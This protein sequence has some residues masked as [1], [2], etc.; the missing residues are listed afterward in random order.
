MKKFLIIF[1]LILIIAGGAYYAFVYYFSYSHGYRA[2]ELVKF[3]QKGV[4]F[5]TW[6]GQI[7]QE[8]T[9]PLWDFSVLDKE[10]EVIDL[11]KNLQGKHVKLTYKERFKTFPWWGDTHYFISEVEEANPQEQSR[12]VAVSTDKNAEIIEELKQENQALRE[13]NEKLKED[14]DILKTTVKVLRDTSLN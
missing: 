13:E 2:G 4:V 1:V 6:E 9:Q 5:R 10:E 7:S 11:L 12:E 8:A 3:S 14:V